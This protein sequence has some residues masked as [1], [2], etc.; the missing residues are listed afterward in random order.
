MQQCND[1]IHA[2]A[3]EQVRT[4]KDGHDQTDG[5]DHG[6]DS[7]DE[8]GSIG[9]E[10]WSRVGGERERTSEGDKTT[11]HEGVYEHFV[12]SHACF[13]GTDAGDELG[14]LLCSD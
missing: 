5:E 3:S 8:A 2:I 1:T 4:G 9:L 10:P 11:T 13:L 6:A 7:A 12:D 14:G